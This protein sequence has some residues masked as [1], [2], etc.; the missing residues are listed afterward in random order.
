DLLTGV[1]EELTNGSPDLVTDIVRGLGS[2]LR[3]KKLREKEK[4][5]LM[6]D[7]ELLLVTQ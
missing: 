3:K 7:Y 5:L 2:F 1:S 4:I 6:D